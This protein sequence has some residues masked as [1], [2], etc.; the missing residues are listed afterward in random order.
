MRQR[1]CECVM[2]TPDTSQREVPACFGA[3]VIAPGRSQREEPATPSRPL[4]WVLRMRMFSKQCDTCDQKHLSGLGLLFNDESV[5]E[6]I[7]YD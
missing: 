4:L 7:I 3:V 2:V 1:Q 6:R 5:G